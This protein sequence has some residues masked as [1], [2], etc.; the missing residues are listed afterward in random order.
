MSLTLRS[1]SR[2][3]G[4]GE[5]SEEMGN[6]EKVQFVPSRGSRVMGQHKDKKQ[7]ITDAM[8]DLRLVLAGLASEGEGRKEPN[9]FIQ[10]IGSLARACSVFL[11]KV[12]VRDGR[13]GEGRLLDDELLESLE[14]RLQPLRKVPRKGRRKIET[15]WVMNAVGAQFTRLDEVTG[16]PVERYVAAG[17]E[18]G[19]SIVVEWPLPGMADWIE[20]PT[21]ERRW[22][23]SAENLFDASAERGMNCSEWLGQQVVLFDGKGITLEKLIRTV[24]NFEGAHAFNV[25]RLST[26]E[27]ERES[28]PAKDPH[29]HILRNI[30]FFG[31]GYAELVVI[32]AA[33]YLLER[34][35]AE[36][37]I[38]RPDGGGF[39]LIR[40]GFECPAEE[41]TSSRPSWLT[42]KGGVMVSFGDNPGIVQHTVRAPG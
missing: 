29:V 20:A 30:A 21:A 35:I 4:T 32:E 28:G 41:S 17:G 14:M 25:G 42:Y 26:F 22:E 38:E 10:L 18:Q 31:H 34:L 2:S 7:R 12:V 33:L 5:V 40:P 19:L 1:R 16:K 6:Q 11:R 8:N 15:E 27:G 36:P 39:Y 3:E 13:Q 9:E 37:T 24:A 23:V